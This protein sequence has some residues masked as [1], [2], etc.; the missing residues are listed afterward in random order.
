MEKKRPSDKAVTPSPT[1]ESRN[2]KAD[3]PGAVEIKKT[4]D[5]QRKA[6]PSK[7]KNKCF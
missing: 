2:H 4:V 3:L 5:S 7:G 6:L 1:K